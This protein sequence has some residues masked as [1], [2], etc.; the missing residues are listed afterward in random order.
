MVKLHLLHTT[1]LFACVWNSTETIHPNILFKARC[2]SWAVL[3]STQN[4]TCD[5]LVRPVKFASDLYD[6]LGRASDESVVQVFQYDYSTLRYH[7][8]DIHFLLLYILTFRD[9]QGF[10][11]FERVLRMLN[12]ANKQRQLYRGN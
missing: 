7:F 6:H 2:V 5:D 8:E 12:Y 3:L 9:L 1:F 11:H 4:V 10:W